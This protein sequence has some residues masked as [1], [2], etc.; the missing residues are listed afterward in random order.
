M[1]VGR[2]IEPQGSIYGVVSA[3]TDSI[4]NHPSYGD[5][6]GK[7]SAVAQQHSCAIEHNIASL[8]VAQHQ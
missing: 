3:S 5:N 6:F 7:Q 2:N 8:C 1:H 4:V